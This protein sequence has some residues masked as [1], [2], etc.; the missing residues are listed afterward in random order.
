[1]ERAFACVSFIRLGALRFDMVV[2]AICSVYA[3]NSRQQLVLY[4]NCYIYSKYTQILKSV[5]A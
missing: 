4:T 2:L 5:R 1:M 3:S